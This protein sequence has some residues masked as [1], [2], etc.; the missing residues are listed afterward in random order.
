M[1]SAQRKAVREGKSI[2]ARKIFK[3]ALFSGV[4]THVAVLLVDQLALGLHLLWRMR[5]SKHDEDGALVSEH[6]SWRAYLR[7][8]RRDILLCM[9][10]LLLGACGAAVGT[11]IKPGSGTRVGFLAGSFLFL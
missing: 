9:G 1:A 5:R 2:A 8:L 11:Q 3:T 10:R 7:K 6:L 4:V